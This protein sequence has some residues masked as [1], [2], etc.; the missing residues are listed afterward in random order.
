MQEWGFSGDSYEKFWYSVVEGK[1]LNY[2]IRYRGG[3][4]G[5]YDGIRFD[6]DFDYLYQLGG[7]WYGNRDGIN[8]MTGYN[9]VSI[10]GYEKDGRYYVSVN[11]KPG[12][13][14]EKDKID[15]YYLRL[16]ESGH[17]AFVYR[18]NDNKYVN[19]DGV[20]SR[21]YEQIRDLRIMESGHYAYTYMED[22]QWYVNIN[23]TING[24]YE[25]VR[26][27]RIAFSGKYAFV[28]EENGRWHVNING[29][30][31]PG[32]EEISDA[33]NYSLILTEKGKY[34]YRYKDNGEWYVNVNGRVS[35]AYDWISDL[36]LAEGDEDEICRCEET[37]RS[38]YGRKSSRVGMWKSAAS[39]DTLFRVNN[40]S[41]ELFSVGMDHSFSSSYQY[42]YVVVD[43]IR[44]GKSPALRGWYEADKNAFIWNAIEGRD[45]VVYEYRIR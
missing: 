10:S 3:R 1:Q 25:Q 16:T 21:E 15:Y 43:G 39:T 31:S 37:E 26:D 24:G 5:P 38:D 45:L 7:K 35:Q 12:Q 9:W 34:A 6:D 19:I 2:Y 11:G 13:G 36:L 18:E 30:L 8:K 42:E 4:A 28:Y 41:I 14:Y 22:D 44:M 32:Y 20:M 27:L 40:N 17:Y 33:Y 29:K 23:G